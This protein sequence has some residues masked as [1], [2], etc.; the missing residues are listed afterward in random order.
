VF[1]VITGTLDLEEWG[2]FLHI[3]GRIYTDFNEIRSEIDKETERM[4][5]H[6]KGICPEPIS[7]KIYS[8]RVVNLTLVDLPGITKV[9]KSILLIFLVDSTIKPHYSITF[10]PPAPVLVLKQE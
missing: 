4:A 7:L 6:N 8:T 9:C 2:K 5:G 3:K 10:S 1:F